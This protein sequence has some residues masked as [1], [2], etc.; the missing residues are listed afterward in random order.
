MS[1]E[2]KTI[3]TIVDPTPW[4]VRKGHQPHRSGAGKHLDKRTK[5]LRTRQA[6]NTAAFQFQ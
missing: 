1:T 5:R 4:K 6:A 3:L 2:K